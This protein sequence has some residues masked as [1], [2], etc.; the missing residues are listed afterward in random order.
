MRLPVSLLSI[1]TCYFF[2][3]SFI[4][5]GQL[6]AEGQE[7]VPRPE[8]QHEQRCRDTNAEGLW[9]KG[10]HPDREG[11]RGDSLGLGIRCTQV[12]SV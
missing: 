11:H 4:V 7:G 6:W 12:R 10:L 2:F 3:L 1:N 5:P 9:V 8:T